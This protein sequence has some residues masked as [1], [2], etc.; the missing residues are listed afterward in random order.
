[1]LSQRCALFFEDGLA[2]F[3][4]NL[5]TKD[6]NAWALKEE[7]HEVQQRSNRTRRMK[8]RHIRKTVAQ[9]VIGEGNDDA[10][11]VISTAKPEGYLPIILPKD[12][13]KRKPN[14][15]SFPAEDVNSKKSNS[16]HIHQT[17]P[18]ETNEKNLQQKAEELHGSGD[19]DTFELDM[20]IATG[21]AAANLTS[22]DNLSDRNGSTRES[23]AVLANP[24]VEVLKQLHIYGTGSQ[25]SEDSACDVAMM[26]NLSH[27]ETVTPF[28]KRTRD[29]SV[30]E[31]EV[32]K[33]PALENVTSV[34]L[35]EKQKNSTL[36]TSKT[37][38]EATIKP[39]DPNCSPRTSKRITCLPPQDS[40][41][42]RRPV[43]RSMS[44]LKPPSPSSQKVSPKPKWDVGS[45]GPKWDVGSS[46]PK[47]DVRT[48]GP[49]WDVGSSG[50]QRQTRFATA[51]A[52]GCRDIDAQ[53]GQSAPSLLKDSMSR[54]LDLEFGSTNSLEEIELQRRRR[55]LIEYCP[56]FDLGI[57]FDEL[58]EAV[59]AEQQT[60]ACEE[61]P[62]VISSNDSG[63][64]LDKIYATIE[65][66]ARTPVIDKAHK[67]E[68][69]TSSPSA[70]NSYTPVPQAHQ[71]RVLKRVQAQQSP[72]MQNGKK[73]V[74]S[75]NTLEVYNKICSYGGRTQ[76]AIDTE[77]IIDY[78]EWYIYLKDLA[79]SVKPTGWLS[80]S[81]CEIALHG[82][83]KE[84][85][86]QKKCV[87]PLRIGV[88]S[89]T[90]S[91]SSLFCLFYFFSFL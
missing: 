17:E 43:T 42:R 27:D 4:N 6:T 7:Q 77:K 20:E 45:S 66:P 86:K 16:D 76:H 79:D 41:T 55:E 39:V 38:V 34:A 62:V 83:S 61:E 9:G 40:P 56:S 12:N 35:M 46:G 58:V 13:R 49:K 37:S 51:Q 53:Q 26:S 75:K 88:S 67:L 30:L 31:M 52:R 14:D 70:P 28:M 18:L 44:P 32:T 11:M 21:H 19:G 78:G 15:E 65:M 3:L 25:S 59:V 1:M 60:T 24:G 81:T 54:K 22:F 23:T 73:L 50:A 68:Q 90:I 84:L 29:G 80:N 72:Y 48:S 57:T 64:S 36:Q 87:M 63:D 8:N 82:I 10:V 91:Y 69:S 33:E 71:K 47:L 5:S 2:K 74:A 89:V 85:A